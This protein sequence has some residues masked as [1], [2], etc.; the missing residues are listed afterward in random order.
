MFSIIV[1]FKVICDLNSFTVV[2]ISSI[3]YLQSTG[4][5]EIYVFRVMEYFILE[6]D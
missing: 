5:L 2:N 3:F 6:F 1:R 4:V